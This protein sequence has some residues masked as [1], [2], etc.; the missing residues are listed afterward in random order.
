[1]ANR[2]EATSAELGGRATVPMDASTRLALDRTMLAHERTLMAWI[3]TATTLITF[4]F[5]IYKFFQLEGAT[6]LQ[7]RTHQVID[8]R[9]FAM[10]MIAI[11]LLALLL[12]TIQNRQY[13]KTLRKQQREIPYSLATLV[14]GLISALGL[15][16]MIAAIFGW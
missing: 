3:R 12:A 14:G 9:T 10:F 7:S 6:L 13:R 11:G 1:M 5:T 4:G 15:L 2:T 8:A 16:A